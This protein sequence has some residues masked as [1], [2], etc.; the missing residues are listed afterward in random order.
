MTPVFHVIET[1]ATP[2]W[3]FGWFDLTRF[4]IEA[5]VAERHD[6]LG[7]LRAFLRDPISQRSFCDPGRWG[8]SVGRHGP[9]LREKLAA[10]SIRP[11]S[12]SELANRLRAALEDPQFTSPPTPAQRR[13]VEAWLELVRTRGDTAFELAVPDASDSRVEWSYVWL[14]FH[15]FLCFSPEREELAVAVIGYD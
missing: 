5:S 10:D 12:T 1:A 15:E 6:A 7:L 3:D 13:P 8:L 4:R 2:L 9:F 11:L 14:V